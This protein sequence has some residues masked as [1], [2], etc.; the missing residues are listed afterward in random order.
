ME[1][2][3]I[4]IPILSII[5]TC[6]IVASVAEATPYVFAET[7]LITAFVLGEEKKA[8]PKPTE[9]APSTA[10]KAPVEEV[11]EPTNYPPPNIRQQLPPELEQAMAPV[12][13]PLVMTA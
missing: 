3:S 1:N 10:K 12:S 9:V 5:P 6:R 4:A 8:K 7:E 2:I 13:G 11:R